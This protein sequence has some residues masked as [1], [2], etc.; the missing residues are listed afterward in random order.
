MDNEYGEES[1]LAPKLAKG[2]ER[3]IAMDAIASWIDT[4]IEAECPVKTDES[5]RERPARDQY[6]IRKALRE[7][8]YAMP[9]RAEFLRVRRLAR[10]AKKAS[11]RP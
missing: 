3:E 11:G 10:E 7:I 4:I 9:K 6:K 2:E 1:T 5:G 8:E